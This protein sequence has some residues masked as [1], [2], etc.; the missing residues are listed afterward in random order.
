MS[1]ADPVDLHLTTE[2]QFTYELRDASRLLLRLL[3]TRIAAHN[4][5]LQQYF[6]LRQLWDA[7]GTGQ[8][9]LSARLQT[10]QP[11]TV[12]TIDTLE[13]RKLVKRVRGVDDRRVVRVHLTPSG[14]ALR[15]TLLGYAFEFSS[16]AVAGL[17]PNEVTMLRGLL[18]RVRANLHAIEDQLVSELR[19]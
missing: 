4:L 13:K 15:E 1:D 7:D 11:A 5:T 16:Q 18:G 19:A 9:T 6:L 12:A 2:V 3:K 8:S 17:D 10:T 14:R